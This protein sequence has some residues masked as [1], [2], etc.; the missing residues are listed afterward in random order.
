MTKIVLVGA[1]SLQFGT[2][3]LGDIFS[4]SVLDGA[5]IVLNDIDKKAA[6]RMMHVAQDYISSNRLTHKIIVEANLLTALRGAKFVVISIEVG[7]RFKLWDMDWRIPQQY[8]IQQVYG[9]NGGPGGLFHSLRIIPPILEICQKIVDVAPR[10]TV[11]NYSNPMSRICTTVHRR[12]PEL[13]FIGMC[14]E[15]ASLERHLPPMLEQPRA[16]IKYRAAGLNHFSILT[17]VTY[18][19]TGADAYP[20]VRARAEDYFSQM[21]GYSEIL[22]ASRETGKAVE[23][24]GWMNIDTSHITNVRPWSDRWLFRDILERFGYLPIT[25]DSHFGE[26]IQWAHDASDHRGVLDFYTYY[27]NYLGKVAPTI[28]AEL[29]ERV[30]PIVEGILTDSGYEEAA[31]NIPNNGYIKDLPDWIVV[32]VPADVTAKGIQGIEMNLPKGI[33]GLLTNQI[34]IHDMTAEAILNQSRDFVVQAMLVD[35]VVTVSKG[36]PDLVDNMIAEQSPWLDYLR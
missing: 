36:I 11:F 24:E 1:G 25:Y 13:K 31:V 6:D 17:D 14:H 27:R 28:K 9:E 5:E 35:P 26:Y 18:V 21:P 12:F 33:K 23:T 19:D 22:T 15:I 4:S 16:N 10:A 30:V 34:G 7:D 29:H 8:G 2:G 32:E 20:D 3:I